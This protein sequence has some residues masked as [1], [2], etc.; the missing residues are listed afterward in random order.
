MDPHVVVG[1]FTAGA[2]PILVAAQIDQAESL[3][4]LVEQFVEMGGVGCEVPAR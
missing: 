3:A 1:E 2:L 4:A